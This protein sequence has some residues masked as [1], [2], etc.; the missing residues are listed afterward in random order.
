MLCEMIKAFFSKGKTVIN[1]EFAKEK[2]LMEY[3]DLY[4]NLV[5]TEL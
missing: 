5:A 2:M 3:L 1:M 4:A